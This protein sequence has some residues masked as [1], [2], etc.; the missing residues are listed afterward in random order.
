MSSEEITRLNLRH[1]VIPSS[2][3]IASLNHEE[4]MELLEGQMLTLRT[5]IFSLQNEIEQKEQV[6]NELRQ[7]IFN[8]KLQ[9]LK[10]SDKNLT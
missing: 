10:S 7:E 4:K 3:S 2:S 6:I 8:L 1:E 5:T 9:H